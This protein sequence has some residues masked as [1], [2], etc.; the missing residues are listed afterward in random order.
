MRRMHTR[1]EAPRLPS[2]TGYGPS[3]VSRSTPC[4]WR[5]IMDGELLWLISLVGKGLFKASISPEACLT[6]MAS[7]VAAPYSLP[8]RCSK[9]PLSA[10]PRW[11]WP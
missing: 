3:V 2:A 11:R 6:V 7:S 10:R 9:L 5:P 1:V 4:L 8:I